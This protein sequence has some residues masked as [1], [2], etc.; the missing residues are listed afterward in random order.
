MS[1]LVLGPLLRWVG[2][3]SATVWVETGA[4]C[5]VELTITE[6]G[7]GSST[8]A[9]PTLQVRG[10]HYAL[11]VADRLALPAQRPA[12]P[13]ARRGAALRVRLLPPA[14]PARAALDA[15]DQSRPQG[16]RR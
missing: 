7:G 8:F 1:A 12:D 16:P 3:R 11:L 9:E 13:A 10:H 15:A 6:P 14:G 4:P 5:T 2:R